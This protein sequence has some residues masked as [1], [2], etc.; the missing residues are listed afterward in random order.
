MVEQHQK[1]LKKQLWKIAH[2]LRGNMFAD[3]FKGFVDTFVGGF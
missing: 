2:S 3:D 1:E